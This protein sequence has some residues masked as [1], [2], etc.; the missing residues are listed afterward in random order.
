[1]VSHLHA[2]HTLDLVPFAYALLHSPRRDPAAARPALHLPPGGR[3]SS[4]ASSA[5]GAPRR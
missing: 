4:A 2:D 5:P 3:R 1:V